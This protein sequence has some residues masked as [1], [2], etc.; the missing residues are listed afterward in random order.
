MDSTAITLCRENQ[1][2]IIVLDLWTHGA[3]RAA[4]RGEAVGTL[5]DHRDGDV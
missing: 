5:V 3:M 4:V 2:P 1:L